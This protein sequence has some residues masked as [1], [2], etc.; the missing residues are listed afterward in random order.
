MSMHTRSSDLL[1]ALVVPAVLALPLWG[2]SLVDAEPPQPVIKFIF[3]AGGQRGKSV[4]VTVN[5]T[6]LQGAGAVRVSGGGITGQVVKVENPNL[7]RIT[8]TIDPDATVGER[9][10]RVMTPAGGVS[11]RFRF[12]VGELPEINEKE[13]N[14]L[15]SQA[16]RLETL[17]IVVNGQVHPSD[18]DFFRF[19]AKAGETLVCHVQARELLPYIADAVPGWL[20]TCLTLYDADG[21]ELTSVGRFRFNPDPLLIY[22]VPKDGEY[23]IEVR[24]LFYRGREDFVYRLSVGVFPYLTDVF[25][26]GGQRDSDVPVELRGA[27]LPM[28]ST[29]LVLPGNS[30]PLR[31][32][33]VGQN[34][35]SSNALPF[36]VGD[37]RETRVTEANHAFDQASRIE[38]PVTL[39][40]R[41]QQRGEAHYFRFAVKKGQRFIMEVQARR[42]GSPLDSI[43]T[44]FNS[45]GGQLAEQD[46]TDMGDPLLTHHADSRLDYAFPSDGDY[47]L[48][49]Q[50]V[51]GRG[52]EEF[53]YRL[54]IVPP[55]PDFS[56]RTVPD[57]PRLGEADSAL[58]TVKA[59]RQDGFNGEIDLTVQNLPKGFVASK[60]V[61]PAG[62]SE[63]RL[64]VTAPPDAPVGLGLPTIVGTATLGE[65]TAGR[66]AVGAEDIMQAF[67]L[68]HDVPTKEF[69]VAVIESPDF[70]LSTNIPSTEVREVRQESQ[71]LVVVK[72][73]R[74]GLE[75]AIARAEAAKKAAEGALARLKGESA[76]AAADYGTAQ[77][78]AQETEGAA[79]KSKAAA[80]EAAATLAN[81]LKAV[82]AKRQQA[83]EAKK[84]LDGLAQEQKKAAGPALASVN[85]Q[86]A[87]ATR[88]YEADEKAVKDA[89]T[90][91]A[92]ARAAAD[93]AQQL[94][95]AA[96]K[97]AGE[98]RRLA[99]EAK[100]KQDK[101]ATDEKAAASALD[102]AN[103]SLDVAKQNAKQE[104]RLT[105]D[106]L[107][108]GVTFTPANIAPDKSEATV[109][110]GITPQ[111]PVGQRQNIIITGTTGSG[112]TAAV[113][114]APALPIKVIESAK[115]LQAV[116]VA[117]RQQA[118]EAKKKLDDLVEKQQKPAEAGLAAAAQATT[119]ATTAKAA[120]DKAL[121]EA[122]DAAAKAQTI[123]QAAEKVANEAETKAQAI[124]KDAGKSAVEK[125]KVAEEAAA[126]RKAA[127]AA[128]AGLAETQN[129]QHQAQTQ[130]DA[131]AKKLAEAEA[132]KK[133]V[134]QAL[135][136]VKNQV[137]AA[138]T[139]YQQAEAA[140]KEAELA[141]AKAKS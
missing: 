19:A 73:S 56:L 58:V 129:K 38:L 31:L 100:A 17:P 88:A 41:I 141:A 96:E 49:I 138:S 22:Q 85:N 93:K 63:T 91:A 116:A 115:A 114:V 106:P 29:K 121:A 137:A 103:K 120:T 113:H 81:A 112:D 78:T 77:K 125:K 15:K 110:L 46:D 1:R 69:L 11:N 32:V 65:Q 18:T 36:A 98:N 126:G 140:A 9:D 60:A 67:S 35:L 117:K 4:D 82:A 61:I 5:G 133:A 74:K 94:Q 130:S 95:A 33:S 118:N 2:P 135:A 24:D 75:A 122:R 16:Q 48:R 39:N 30:S 102:Q 53:A 23:L 99:N 42:L 108:G 90:A 37:H 83:T 52:G 71:V 97:T 6:G 127:D 44:L 109:T 105:A 50:D 51:Q 68:R 59:L 10:L 124:A 79:A 57:N 45:Q 55:R 47:V 64:T 12:F 86:L 72:A 89:E 128:K 8:V 134:E 104:I 28:K 107:P 101:L 70:T 54:H 76:K 7:V 13:P 14:S 66:Q 26:L 80:A 139:V 40:G 111:A 119:E 34:G 136:G 20:E 3:P 132:Q 87:D 123:L 92:T 131:A 21:K 27:N 25:P 62:Q 84:K 43:I